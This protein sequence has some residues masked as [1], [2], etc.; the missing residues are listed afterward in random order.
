MVKE[1]AVVVGVAAAE[2]MAERWVK[3]GIDA[4]AAAAAAPAAALV[5]AAVWGR[6]VAAV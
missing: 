3:P 4:A 5:A 1:T 6:A 2:A